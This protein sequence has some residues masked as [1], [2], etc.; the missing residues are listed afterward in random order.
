[1]VTA[2]QTDERG[3]VRPRMGAP[4]NVFAK[5][6]DPAPLR[7]DAK[8][9]SAIARE[10]GGRH[11]GLTSWVNFPLVNSTG[12][13]EDLDLSKSREQKETAYAMQL[14]AA[15]AIVEW[16]RQADFHVQHARIAV[17]FSRD[18][19]R[20]QVDMHHSVRLLVQLNDQGTDFRHVFAN[21][22]VAM[23]AGEV[24][25]VDG[26]VCHGAANLAEA[27]DRV[28]LIVDCNPAPDG[29]PPWYRGRWKI[30]RNRIVPR[31]KWNQ[32]SR[33]ECLGRAF[34]LAG[35]RG[36]SFAEREWLFVP[37][38]YRVE[39]HAM[40]SE[41][42]DFCRQMAAHSK[43]QADSALWTGRALY[44]NAHDCV[45]VSNTDLVWSEAEGKTLTDPGN[46]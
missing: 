45:C 37:Y 10:I 5:K 24:W 40:Y 39:P 19:L 9:G 32:A 12:A 7:S 44:W 33:L 28:M 17:L 30:P 11:S 4:A 46:P 35:Q 8:T 42:I 2:I 18:L 15:M 26:S 22:C 20:P 14:P 36:H 13:P 27:G 31:K 23:K 41:L 38:E 6:F 34:E 21:Y 43:Q 25:G 29:V 1:M 16:L 3:T